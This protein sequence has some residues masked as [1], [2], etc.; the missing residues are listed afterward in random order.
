MAKGGRGRSAEAHGRNEARKGALRPGQEMILAD[1][2]G[3]RLVT[4]SRDYVAVVPEGASEGAYMVVERGSL[5]RPEDRPG[6]G[7][8]GE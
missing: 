4:V 1:G 5:T 8:G 2:D 3:E 6:F 7:E